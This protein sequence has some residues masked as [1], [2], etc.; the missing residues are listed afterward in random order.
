MNG[1][2]Q[3]T[4]APRV[5]IVVPA[6]NREQFIGATL[7]SVLAQSMTS[8]ELVVFDDGSTDAT[9]DIAKAY[10]ARDSRI[11]VRSGPNGGVA[12]AR[13]RGF[14]ATDSRSEFVV[15]LDSDD[16]W[17]PDTL[18]SLLSVLETHPDNVSVYGLARCIDDHGNAIPGD[19]LEATMRARLQ[20]DHGVLE[21]VPP[22]RPTTFAG[23]AYHNW[24]ITPG[25]HLIRREV[26]DRAGTF[27][28]STDPADDWDLVLRLSRHGDIGYLEQIVMHWRRH[29]NTLT[30]TSPRWRRAY[31]KVR[32]KMLLDPSNTADQLRLARM[33][34]RSVASGDLGVLLQAVRDREYRTAL[35]RGG[36]VLDDWARYAGAA[37]ELVGSRLMLRWRD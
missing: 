18:E 30:M 26:L 6:Y 37:L 28:P 22:G 4:P 33:G 17:E 31:F 36:R 32:R 13:N 21:P 8:W 34:F 2:K 10:S 12:A 35:H 16:V 1:S 29:G 27:D 3:V 19:D 15:F 9:A 23:L 11:S 5:S 14:A 25:I 20:F 24:V 7:N